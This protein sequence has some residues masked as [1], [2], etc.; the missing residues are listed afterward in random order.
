M[1]EATQIL[2]VDI[3]N[4]A[5]T[6]LV[7]KSFE[8]LFNVNDK[9]KGGSFYLQSK[10]SMILNEN[11]FRRCSNRIQIIRTIGMIYYQDPNRILLV[12]IILM[13]NYSNHQ[14]MT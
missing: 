1:Q 11:P 7:N 9:S 3:K 6:E 12:Q 5:D 14:I 10:V 13:E 4:I 2:N 8:H